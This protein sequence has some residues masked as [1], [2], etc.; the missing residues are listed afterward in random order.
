MTFLELLFTK[1]RGLVL[2]S[3]VKVFVFV[4]KYHWRHS[5]FLEQK[6]VQQ[7]VKWLVSLTKTERWARSGS[8]YQRCKRTHKHVHPLSP[9]FVK[10]LA[11]LFWVSCRRVNHYIV[12]LAVH[13]AAEQKT[14]LVLTSFNYSL[15]QKLSSFSK[16]WRFFYLTAAFHSGCWKFII[17]PFWFG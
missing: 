16:S 12:T 4:L 13:T 8:G 5:V 9:V 1:S 6:V 7:S 11:G 17:K 3:S 2:Y 14:V 15:S 10:T